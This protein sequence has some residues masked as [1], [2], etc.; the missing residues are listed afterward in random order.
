MYKKGYQYD[1]QGGKIVPVDYNN[2]GV[3]QH[4][5][6]WS[7]GLAQFLQIKEGLKVSPETISTNFISTVGFF[8]RY[9]NQLY[10][11]TGTLGNEVTQSFFKEVYN[12]DLV[13]V[14]PYK[15][16][17]IVGNADSPYACKELTPQ[18][19][20]DKDI[21]KWYDAIE[22]SDLQHAQQ[23]RAVLIICKYVKQVH[24]LQE[25]LQRN[26]ARD[27]IFTYTGKKKFAK[28][29]V[30]PGEI[31]IATNIAGRGTDLTPSE[32]V[33]HHGGLHVCITF[34]PGNYRVE[35][36]NAGRTARRLRPRGLARL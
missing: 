22:A 26:Y 13:I 1:V 7:N 28:E 24:A 5:M 6:I 36:Q 30:Y 14:P 20:A 12:T 15:K 23:Q 3:W 16:R 31:I 32:L 8:Q 2:T 9:A 17:L 34:L 18:L 35:L 33:E 27:K 25:R 19:I 29:K 10:G 4:S 11:L 21:N